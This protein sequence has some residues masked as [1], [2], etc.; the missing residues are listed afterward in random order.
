MSYKTLYADKSIRRIIPFAVVFA[1]VVLVYFFPQD[2][3]RTL[4]I[5]VALLLVFFIYKFDM[6]IFVFFAIGLLIIGAFLTAR[7]SDEPTSHL[8]L[9]SFWLLVTGIIGIVIDLFRNVLRDKQEK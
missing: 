9:I 5:F 2:D 7:G 3:T 1:A 4:L 8:A 6:R